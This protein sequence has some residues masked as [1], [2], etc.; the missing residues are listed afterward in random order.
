MVWIGNNTNQS[1]FGAI[2][3]HALI[4]TS[5]SL[6]PQHG[7]HYDPALTALVAGAF[8]VLV[9]VFWEAKNLTRLRL[10]RA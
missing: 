10:A 1:V 4:N 2:V 5:Y 8:V 3:F 6:S 7:A 9:L